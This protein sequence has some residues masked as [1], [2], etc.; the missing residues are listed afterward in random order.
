LVRL[1]IRLG[2][3]LK[4]QLCCTYEKLHTSDRQTR[5]TGGS[6]S[7]AE[8]VIAIIPVVHPDG[9]THPAA[10]F[11]SALGISSYTYAEAVE[12]QQIAN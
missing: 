10:L 3:P 6:D 5:R 7:S 8:T 11:G 2:N 1:Q 4:P 12:E 9:G